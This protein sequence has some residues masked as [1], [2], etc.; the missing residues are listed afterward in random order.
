MKY[1]TPEIEALSKEIN[2]KSLINQ[3]A[4]CGIFQECDPNNKTNKP[5]F[6]QLVENKSK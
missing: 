1:L 3:S 5:Y 6:H 4:S 2:P